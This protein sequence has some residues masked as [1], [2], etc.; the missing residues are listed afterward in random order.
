MQLRG[1]GVYEPVRTVDDILIGEHLVLHNEAAERQGLLF[2]E[3]HAVVVRM[4]KDEKDVMLIT[5]QPK[6]DASSG[7]AEAGAAASAPATSVRSGLGSMVQLSL[8]EWLRGAPL[9]SV[10]M[11]P[12]S[13]DR[14][15]KSQAEMARMCE[16]RQYA[17]ETARELLR[18]QPMK[19]YDPLL[20][21]DEQVV[22]F[23]T[24]STWRA[25]QPEVAVFR[26]MGTVLPAA[27]QS[28][29]TRCCPLRSFPPPSISPRCRRPMG[30]ASV[31]SR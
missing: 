11:A 22:R 13:S 21:S 10:L 12:D 29:R 4:A 3:R 27:A 5:F 15:P 26:L 16:A 14:S 25:R 28:D 6:E 20:C 19:L 1:E 31:S 8:I 18:M 30:S 17:C 7:K 24:L 23:C 9:S 2:S